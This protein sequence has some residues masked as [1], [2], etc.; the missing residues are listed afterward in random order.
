METDKAKPEKPPK[1][2]LKI[3]KK[4]IKVHKPSGI[5]NKKRNILKFEGK[6]LES[7]GKPEKHA[8]WFITGPSFSGKSSL[9]FELCVAFI[10]VGVVDYA[11]Y[12]EAGGDS[13]TVGDKLTKNGLHTQDG[14]IR[15]FK[16]PIES[17]THETLGERTGK[18]DSADF[19]VV[20][21]I[22]HAEMTK[23]QYLKLTDDFS[24]TKKSKSLLFV[25]HWVK[26]EFTKFVKHDCDIKI[27]VIGFVAHVES[28]F[29][30]NK[31]YLIWEDGAKKYWGKKY[32]AVMDGK[33]WPGQKN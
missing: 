28:R 21:S 13:Q 32:K 7:V 19:I 9:L 1:D 8:K 16:A 24:N 23:K 26:N 25:S 2:P 29:G 14:K 30:G 6:L 12:E 27:E 20:D 11:N 33:Y 5:I 18:R 3:R 22:Q 17:D 15:L 10:A 4:R 31:P